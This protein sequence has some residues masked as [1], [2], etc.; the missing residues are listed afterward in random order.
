MIFRQAE[1][2]A[3]L[4]SSMINYIFNFCFE[5]NNPG[6]KFDLDSLINI[7]NSFDDGDLTIMNTQKQQDFEKIIYDLDSHR[8]KKE[9]EIKLV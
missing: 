5:Q 8:K 4:Q 9:S 3:M 7:I 6:Y 1:L 2:G